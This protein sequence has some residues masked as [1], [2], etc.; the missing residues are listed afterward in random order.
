M[1]TDLS[2]EDWQTAY[3]AKVKA[4]PKENDFIL[5]EDHEDTDP[6]NTIAGKIKLQIEL[7]QGRP[8]FIYARIFVPLTV[9]HTP[10][11]VAH[12]V[13]SKTNHGWKAILH[14]RSRDEVIRKCGV[15]ETMVP[16]KRL[17]VIR[18]SE[19]GQSIVVVIDEW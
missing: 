11:W 9:G 18:A 1:S 2:I 12:G 14:Q 4:P 19:T 17:R 16:V 8:P 13:K 10:E 7:Q 3:E 6:E 15:R 5:A